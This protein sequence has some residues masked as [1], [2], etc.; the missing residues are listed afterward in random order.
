MHRHRRWLATPALVLSLALVGAACSGGSESGDGGDGGQPASDLPACPIDALETATGPTDITLWY[1]ISGQAAD[2][3]EAMVD[4]YN[5]SQD[6]V[7]VT[8]E[9][10][11]A[12]YD[13]LLR[14]YEQAIPGNT[15]PN[16]VVAE[17]TATQFLVDSDTVIP[18]QSC[19]DA[20]GQ[21]TEP[22]ADVAVNHFTVD[23]AMWAGTASISDLLTYYNKNH[24]RQAGLDPEVAPKTLDE[25][26]T[27]AEAIRDAGV[28]PTPV[29]L[30]MD[31]WLVET[32]LTGSKQPLVNNENGYGDGETTEATFD[33][34]QT[35]AVFDW[36]SEMAAD[37]LLLPTQATAGNQD[38]YLAMAAGAGSI[39][40]ETSTAATTIETFLGG[41]TSVAEGVEAPAEVDLDAL[42][43][44]AGP[45]FGVDEAGKAQLGGNGFFLT[46]SGTDAQKAAAWDL[47][48]W[49]NEE[50]QQVRWHVEGSYLPFLD[51]AADSPEV[52]T[53]WDTTMAGGFLKT[54]YDELTQN[55]DP[56]FT[57]ALIGPYDKFRVAMREALAQVA[58]E[59]GDPAAAIA[60]AKAETDAALE[61]YNDT[62]F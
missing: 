2:T 34:D 4:D 58:F 6:R 48:S 41:D 29:V 46:D 38:H 11:G 60:T 14:A 42:D 10:Q 39:T 51:A 7:R 40:V 18:A 21:S 22:F 35:R 55:M 25:V 47:I 49:W 43:I 57:G 61:L 45:V 32:Q 23:G 26:R 36:I 54:A 50:P 37:G 5:A 15:L 20:A 16:I 28:T 19:F 44:G 24:L 13:E 8:A 62:N 53:F 31:S 56:D 17:D 12:S 27:M 9:N 59:G 52:Q 1:Q 3:L 33:T 30:R